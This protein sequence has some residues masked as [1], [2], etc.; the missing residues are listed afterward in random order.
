MQSNSSLEPPDWAAAGGLGQVHAQTR[1]PGGRSGVVAGRAQAATAMKRAVAATIPERGLRRAAGAGL[2]VLPPPVPESPQ[3]G[4]H[5]STPLSIRHTRGAIEAERDRRL[6]RRAH[7]ATAFHAGARARDV[8]VPHPRIAAAV[9]A[10]AH[11]VRREARLDIDRWDEG[12]LSVP[13][14]GPDAQ[15]HDQEATRCSS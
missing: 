10:D 1:R 6:Q 11:A 14:R 13:D 15:Q 8:G 5:E 3:R 7:A 9:A 12:R 2:A 4:A